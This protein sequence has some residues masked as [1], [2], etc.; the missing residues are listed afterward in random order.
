MKLH[1]A[2]SKTVFVELFLAPGEWFKAEVAPGAS[3]D[4]SPELVEAAKLGF[5]LVEKAPEKAEKKADK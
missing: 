3:V 2:G 1:N 4:V 5:G